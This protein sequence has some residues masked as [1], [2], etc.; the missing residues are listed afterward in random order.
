MDFF[1]RQRREKFDIEDET[2]MIVYHNREYIVAWY[3]KPDSSND[4]THLCFFRIK[5]SNNERKE[6][7]CELKSNTILIFKGNPLYLDPPCFKDKENPSDFK[8]RADTIEEI[9]SLLKKINQTNEHKDGGKSKV[10]SK[11]LGKYTIAELK[12]NAEKR[13]IDISGLKKKADIFAK[14]R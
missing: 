4:N 11:P 1:K 10:K 6:V 9:F 13:G 5:D 2:L 3:D 7:A 12:S 8:I 14:L